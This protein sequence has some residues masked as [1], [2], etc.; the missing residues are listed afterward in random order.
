MEISTQL[1]DHDHP[2]VK[3]TALRLIEGETT[4]RGRLE[5][6]FHYVRDEIQFGFPAGGDF[7]RASETIESRFGQCNTKSTA[8][9]AL[10]RAAGIPARIR[11]SLIS[12]EIQHGFF[13]GLAYALMPPRISHSWVE[14]LVDGRWRRIDA[15]INDKPLQE[16]AV[17]A[18]RRRGWR[19]GFSVALPR[20]GEPGIDLDLDDEK[21]S[22]MAAVTDDHG[23]YDD[24][25]AYYADSRYQNRPGKFK[26]WMYR[27]LIGRVND[28]VRRLRRGELV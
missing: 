16:H 8:L 13:A 23:T 20:S 25:S 6:L 2:L 17:A 21:F 9:L 27:H 12:K 15:Y 10:C 22:Q 1:A 11:F 4:V 19:T 5:K 3:A 24:P 14:V 28:R 18:L 7:V 26:L